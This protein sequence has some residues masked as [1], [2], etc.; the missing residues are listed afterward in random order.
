MFPVG[1]LSTMSWAVPDEHHYQAVLDPDHPDLTPD[2]REVYQRAI[3]SP[4]ERLMHRWLPL[5]RAVSQGR[6]PPALA[7]FAGMVAA[8]TPDLANPV[9][10]RNHGHLMD[11]LGAG[12][13]PYQPDRALVDELVRRCQG[14]ELPEWCRGMYAALEPGK[15]GADDLPQVVGLLGKA[16]EDQHPEAHRLAH[17][18]SADFRAEM[19]SRGFDV[20][21]HRGSSGD[22]PGTKWWASHPRTASRYAAVNGGGVK[23]RQ[24]TMKRPY[25][26]RSVE[27]INATD[28]TMARLRQ[29]GHDGMVTQWGGGIPVKSNPNPV[30]EIW[31][32]SFDDLGKSE[33]GTGL[34]PGSN[35]RP[36]HG[37]LAASL[38][39]AGH[40]P[41]YSADPAEDLDDGLR[42]HPAH[43][44][45][46]RTWPEYFAGRE[47]EGLL[48]ALWLHQLAAPHHH[49]R[50]MQEAAHA[51]DVADGVAE[52]LV[53][54]GFNPLAK[55]EHPMPVHARAL[56]ALEAVRL[57]FGVPRALMAFHE[58]V[59]PAL[60][61]TEGAL[62]KA[63][64]ALL[65]LR[66]EEGATRPKGKVVHF[67]NR[68]VRPGR[69]QTTDGEL[70]LLHDRG[71]AYVA[72]G[73]QGLV[74][75]PKDGE[76]QTYR[77][78]EPPRG[79]A[80]GILD[81]DH[82]GVAHLNTSPEQRALVHGTDLT[83][84]GGSPQRDGHSGGR[85]VQ[86]GGGQLAFC[87]GESVGGSD[88]SRE[89]VFHNLARDRFGLGAYVPLTAAFDDPH[90]GER[91]SLQAAVPE[92][93][94]AAHEFS[95]GPRRG[96]QKDLLDKLGRA[97]ELDKL[98]VM[99]AVMGSWDRS[100]HNYLYTPGGI[101]LIDNSGIFASGRH[102]PPHYWLDHHRRPGLM[103]NL[104]PEAQEWAMGLDGSGIAEDLL[105]YGQP[106]RVGAERARR[107]AQVQRLLHVTQGRATRAQV[108]AAAMGAMKEG[109]RKSESNIHRNNT[110]LRILSRPGQLP[111]CW[112]YNDFES[113]EP[114]EGFQ[115]FVDPADALNAA[116]GHESDGTYGLRDGYTHVGLV[117]VGDDGE[118]E[119]GGPGPW[120]S[121]R[122]SS[123]R[124]FRQIPIEEAHRLADMSVNY[125]KP[126][127]S[128]R[129]EPDGA[130]DLL[131][132][133]WQS[134]RPIEPTYYDPRKS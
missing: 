23:T 34:E 44:H 110:F 78:L 97:G 7:R 17:L 22:D 84:D 92:A 39:G 69:A 35:P 105:R 41:A 104:H 121:V 108:I 82:H 68:P 93:Q 29:Q 53:R 32:V 88:P 102:D 37:R 118:V 38:T 16:E 94:H 47:D 112:S 25:V 5:N 46:L 132:K 131:G 30:K 73:A 117:H 56:R 100:R 130:D 67:L 133:L 87:K 71:D 74:K 113:G 115:V 55:A 89:V 2:E 125:D 114:A 122:P 10:A 58:A 1:N 21:M 40:L 13:D 6:T 127:E 80:D 19:E 91:H 120:Y 96:R 65:T 134:A 95:G 28:G 90:T 24:L 101:R 64:E 49:R 18:S 31:A 111:T 81:A 36:F 66:K 62:L 63:E 45:V 75:L 15:G 107:M 83:W 43:L 77:V 106:E 70:E 123:V 20:P 48:P 119:D 85:W 42:G 79:L 98:A 59:A 76:G 3:H 126:W 109:M 8:V 103:Q 128:D 12:L 51:Q 54:E 9:Q 124:E 61:S 86:G 60:M 26:A 27:I 4:F 57:H 129:L 116:A 72:R 11:M 50:R 52:L 14:G 99:D 33:F